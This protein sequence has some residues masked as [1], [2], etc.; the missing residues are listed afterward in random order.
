[1]KIH[2]H[3]K[4]GGALGD[5]LMH[6]V[7]ATSGGAGS[8]PQ[9]S[10][11]ALVLRVTDQRVGLVGQRD[12]IP[13]WEVPRAWVVRVERRPRL[14]L[15]ARFRLHYADGSWLAFMTARRR[16]VEGFQALIG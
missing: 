2:G 13:V 12:G 8:M 9:T 4:L 15:L 11:S 16:T 14:Q 3:G 7:G 6:T 1:V 5:H 10:G